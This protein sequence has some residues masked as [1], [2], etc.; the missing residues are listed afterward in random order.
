MGSVDRAPVQIVTV[1]SPR[2]LRN[3]FNFVD[4]STRTTKGNGLLCTTPK[5]DRVL[6]LPPFTIIEVD[7]DRKG[8]KIIMVYS[9]ALRPA[10][11]S[12]FVES[13][14]F[15]PDYADKM[16]DQYKVLANKLLAHELQENV[17]DFT[18]SD[19]SAFAQESRELADLRQQEQ[20]NATATKK[21]KTA[22]KAAS[23]REAN[24]A[25]KA[26]IAS[27]PGLGVAA[28]LSA[29][30]SVLV[31][32]AVSVSSPVSQLVT[33][34]PVSEHVAVPHPAASHAHAS[35]SSTGRYGDR[36]RSQPV[37]G[38]QAYCAVMQSMQSRIT[39]QAAAVSASH[40]LEHFAALVEATAVFAEDDVPV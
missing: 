4:M 25:N 17:A 8:T 29:A 36:R 10:G 9:C 11:A 18:A 37:P 32:P 19:D 5:K 6:L 24:K 33:A 30:P 3:L 26:A 2:Q 20:D 16:S 34:A 31:V 28:R 14:Q 12:G 39:A 1:H 7:H 40:D 15:A 13:L 38:T 22:S 21:Q 27:A 23:S 35:A